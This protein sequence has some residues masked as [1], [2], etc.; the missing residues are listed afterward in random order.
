VPGWEGKA[1]PRIG[2]G[3]ELLSNEY[4]K[5]IRKPR[6]RPNSKPTKPEHIIRKPRKPT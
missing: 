1:I 5:K 4:A 2:C 6:K 3:K